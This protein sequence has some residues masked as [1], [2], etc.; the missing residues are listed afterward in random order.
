MRSENLEN[1]E[2]LIAMLGKEIT[3]KVKDHQTIKRLYHQCE[4]LE[5]ICL[6]EAESLPSRYK[7]DYLSHLKKLQQNFRMIINEYNATIRKVN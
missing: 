4:R 7:A 5:K 6:S 3:R 2:H 1:Y